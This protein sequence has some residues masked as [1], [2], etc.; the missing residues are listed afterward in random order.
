MQAIE[1]IKTLEKPLIN[2]HGNAL[3]VNKNMASSYN[4][5]RTEKQQKHNMCPRT[6]GRVNNSKSLQHQINC[7]LKKTV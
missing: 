7:G 4:R 5:A 2:S 1:Y 3:I 6:L